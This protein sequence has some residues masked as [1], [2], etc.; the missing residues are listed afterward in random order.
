MSPDP[1]VD[2]VDSSAK[3]EDRE[4]PTTDQNN[5]AVKVDVEKVAQIPPV[6]FFRLFQFSTRLE[7]FLDIIGLIAAAL[8]GSAQVSSS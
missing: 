4:E 5:P 2:K 7:I 3:G 8:V 6:S 1:V